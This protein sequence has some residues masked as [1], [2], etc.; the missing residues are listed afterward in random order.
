MNFINSYKA[1]NKTKK[2]LIEL[3]VGT[4][5]VVE[6]KLCFCNAKKCSKFRF[7]LFNF[8]FEL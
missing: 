2:Y 5:T 4:M 7:M 6:I 1:K 8:G 3:R